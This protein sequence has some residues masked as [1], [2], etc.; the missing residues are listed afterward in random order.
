MRNVLTMIVA[1]MLCAGGY[2]TDFKNVT[3]T[4]KLD[5]LS[6]IAIQQMEQAKESTSQAK[7]FGGTSTA[8]TQP[9]ITAIVKMTQGTDAEVLKSRGFYIAP[10]A[11]NFCTITTTLDSLQL[12]GEMNDVERISFGERKKELMLKKANTITGVDLIH[13]G[14]TI[15]NS[16][17]DKASFYLPQPYTGKGVMIADFDIGFDPNHVMFLDK[18]G[19][20]RFKVIKDSK[21]GIITDEAKIA[22][23][24]TDNNYES[25]ATHVCGI[26]AGNYEGDNYSIRGVAP[27]A[28]LAM[29]PMATDAEELDYMRYLAEYC[30]S[31]NERLIVNM[32]YGSRVGP[33]D[34]SD[35]YSQA[36]SALINKYDIVVTMSVGN[37]A[38]CDIAAKHTLTDENDEMKGIWFTDES[39][40]LYGYLTT[41]QPTPINMDIVVYDTRV[42]SII[43]NYPAII[44]GEAQNLSIKNT[45][46]LISDINIIKESIHNG[47]SGY[48]I[49]SQDVMLKKS[50]Y[51][52]G[53]VIK[54]QAGQS[55]ANYTG[56][57]TPFSREFADWSKDIT[58]N[59]SNSTESGNPDVIVVGAY[60]TASSCSFKNGN[61]MALGK[62]WGSNDGDITYYSSFGERFD[63]ECIPQVCAPGAILESSFN[64]YDASSFDQK[65]IMHTDSS[66]GKNYSF[67]AMDGTS[68]AAPYMAGIAALWLEANPKLT[69]QE[70]KEIAMNTANSDSYCNENNYFIAQG[71]QAGKGKVDALAGLEYILGESTVVL[72]ENEA[73][74]TGITGKKNVILKRT[75][76]STSYNTMVLPFDMSAELIAETFG[77]ETKVF[78]FQHSSNGQFSF[79]PSP[80]IEAN[81]PFLM[82]TATTQN[83]F[84][85]DQVEIIEGEPIDQG[86]YYDFKGNYGEKMTLAEGLYFI[87]KG[88][89]YSS[90]GKSSLKGYRAYF[91]ANNSNAAKPI[92]MTIDGMTTN[93]RSLDGEN[94]D[95]TCVIYNLNGQKLSETEVNN[96][97][98]GVYIQQGKKFIIK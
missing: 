18:N 30:Q 14:Q 31:K 11:N 72:D 69:H 46:V 60:N 64:S 57:T 49:E 32:S 13:K 42:N 16:N 90:V 91:E 21:K 67:A 98:K 41:S 66:N 44:N 82:T 61:S 62:E 95:K 12:L 24:T 55:I 96:L 58:S 87:T 63:G 89:I 7:G 70:I 52:I 23:Y 68:M 97:P 79:Y 53:Y 74:P 5:A 6:L 84:K 3:K 25:H 71:K 59:G 17:E 76:S 36:L 8:S 83:T 28:D 39:P 75:L 80:N 19:K 33:K 10:L 20:S 9:H 22:A 93:V 94:T 40:I 34:G 81:K 51:K 37:D 38:D 56:I 35:V 43:K 50:Y 48:F 77:A 26:A 45:G 27:D 65:K 47:M 29:G 1:A 78:K 54:G 2:A 73:M 15:N 85:I 92:T 4:R 88:K 86:E